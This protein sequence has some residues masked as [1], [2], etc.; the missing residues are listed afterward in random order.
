MSKRIGIFLLAIITMIGALPIEVIA[1]GMDDRAANLVGNTPGSLVESND[2]QYSEEKNK[3]SETEIILESAKETAEQNNKSKKAKQTQEKES[4]GEVNT[5]A[6]TQPM[7]FDVQKI[8]NQPQGDILREIIKNNNYGL[9]WNNPEN[10]VGKEATLEENLIEGSIDYL[11]A[12]EVIGNT[13]FSNKI[14]AIINKDDTGKAES[15][16][17]V[18]KTKTEGEASEQTNHFITIRDA[19]LNYP[20]IETRKFDTI[21]GENTYNPYTN[22]TYRDI[23]NQIQRIT[24]G[25]ISS[26]IQEATEVNSPVPNKVTQTIVKTPILAEQ[27]SYTLIIR[28]ETKIGREIKNSYKTFTINTDNTITYNAVLTNGI[29]RENTINWLK[30][31]VNTTDETQNFTVDLTPDNSQKVLNTIQVK[32]YKLTEKGYEEI[33]AEREVKEINSLPEESAKINQIQKVEKQIESKNEMTTFGMFKIAQKTVEAE[34]ITQENKTTEP[35]ERQETEPIETTEE[36]PQIVKTAPTATASTT[37]AASIAA[38]GLEA[39]N[40]VPKRQETETTIEENS[41]PKVEDTTETNT[42]PKEKVEPKP[43][44]ISTIPTDI[45]VERLNRAEDLKEN[46]KSN[47]V[48]T[49]ELAPGEIAIAELKTEIVDP[50]AEHTVPDGKV[51]KRTN[52]LFP[53]EDYE[54]LRRRTVPD[55]ELKLARSRTDSGYEYTV[56]TDRTQVG[57]SERFQVS[58]EFNSSSGHLPKGGDEFTIPI[59][60]NSVKISKDGIVEPLFDKSGKQLG[61]ATIYNDKI[62]FKMYDTVNGLEKV[63]GGLKFW[64][65]GSYTGGRDRP[66]EGTIEIGGKKV[67]VNY[68]PGGSTTNNV[69]RKTGV[70][71]DRPGYEGIVHWGFVIN[72]AQRETEAVNYTIRDTLNDKMDW[73]IDKI[74]EDKIVKINTKDD[75]TKYYLMLLFN[76]KGNIQKQELDG[77]VYYDL[78]KA[79]AEEFLGVKI[80]INGN[81]LTITSSKNGYY[82][83]NNGSWQPLLNKTTLQITLPAKIKEQYLNDKE[84]H[85]V[86][87]TSEVDISNKADWKVEEKDKSY[88]VQLFKSESW[89]KGIQP[90]E[91]K[92]LKVAK[93][94]GDINPETIEGV[95]FELKSNSGNDLS[96]VKVDK[97][98]KVDHTETGAIRIK[99]DENGLIYLKKLPTGEYTL[100]EVEA[101]E[102]VVI[103]SQERIF[104]AEENSKGQ[105]Y[106]IENE[107]KRIDIKVEKEWKDS[108]GTHPEVKFKLLRKIEGSD[109]SE[110]K[111][112]TTEEEPSYSQLTLLSE[113]KEVTWK[114]LRAHDKQSNKPYTYKVEE[115][116]DEINKEE[117]GSEEKPEGKEKE[118]SKEGIVTIGGVKYK[119][120]VEP[121]ETLLDKLIGK[122][123]GTITFKV[124]NEKQDSKKGKFTLK[125]VNER[126]EFLNGA[127]FTLTKKDGEQLPKEFAQKEIKVEKEEGVLVDNLDPGIYLLK[128]TKAPGGYTKTNETATITVDEKG[129]TKV[130]S[131]TR[132]S[133]DI[134]VK[135]DNKKVLSYDNKEL[136]IVIAVENKYPRGMKQRYDDYKNTAES[137]YNAFKNTPGLKGKVNIILAGTGANNTNVVDFNIGSEFQFPEN[138]N[139][140]GWMDQ[141]FT[142]A[143]PIFKNSSNAENILITLFEGAYNGSNADKALRELSSTNINKVFNYTYSETWL[144][145]INNSLIDRYN[146]LNIKTNLGFNSMISKSMFDSDRDLYVSEYITGLDKDRNI[147]TSPKGSHIRENTVAV[148]TVTIQNGIFA[149]LIINK[150]DK[151]DGSK[152]LQGA[153]FTLTK[154]DGTESLTAVSTTNGI[155]IFDKIAPGEYI[156]KETQAPNKYKKIETEW[157]VYVSPT[158]SI[159]VNEK[160]DNVTPQETKG[161]DLS[162][163]LSGNIFISTPKTQNNTLEIGKDS[164]KITI[165]GNFNLNGV[166]AGDYFDLKISNTIHYNMLQPDKPNQPTIMNSAGERIAVPTLIKSSLG[167]EKII[168]YTFVNSLQNVEFQF[169]LDYSVDVFGAK[170][171]GNYKF[172]ANVGHT[173]G[174]IDRQV[175]Y[176]GG[177]SNSYGLNIDA[178][179]DYTNDQNG[180]YSQVIYVNQKGENITVPTHLEITPY[181]AKDYKNG[182]IVANISPIATAIKVYK[183]KSGQSLSNAV[184]Y[185]KDKLE[186]VTDQFKDKIKID[187]GK[188]TIQFDNIG[189]EKYVVVVDSNMIYPQGQIQGTYLVQVAKL[190]NNNTSASIQMNSGIATTDSSSLGSGSTYS[191]NSIEL[192][193][194][195]EKEET[196]K[197]TLKKTDENQKFLKG[198]VFTLSKKENEKLPESFVDREIKID[199]PEGVLVDNLDSGIYMLE[200]KVSPTGYKSNDDYIVIVHQSG[201]TQ[202]IEKKIFDQLDRSILKEETDPEELFNINNNSVDMSRPAKLLQNLEVYDYEL[203]SSNSKDPGIVRPNYG[204]YLITRFKIKIPAEAKEGDYFYTTFDER[205]NRLGNKLFE[206]NIQP[207]KSYTGEELIR[208]SNKNGDNTYK[209]ILTEKVNNKQDFEIELELPLYV[210]RNV[211]KENSILDIVNI[212]PSTGKDTEE[213]KQAD[214][215]AQISRKIRVDYSGFSQKANNGDDYV[216]SAIYY[217][218]TTSTA[219]S[220][221]YLYGSK[222][223]GDKISS[224]IYSRFQGLKSSMNLFSED[225]SIEVYKVNKPFTKVDGTEYKLDP[226]TMPESFGLDSNWIASK[227]KSNTIIKL[228]ENGD[229]LS[230]TKEY[231]NSQYGYRWH[232]DINDD[233]NNERVEAYG[234]I[235]KVNSKYDPYSENPLRIVAG[236]RKSNYYNYTNSNVAFDNEIIN[237]SPSASIKSTNSIKLLKVDE[238]GSMISDTIFKLTSVKGEEVYSQY[239]KTDEKGQIIFGKIKAGDYNLEEIVTAHGYEKPSSGWKISVV[240]DEK[241]GVITSVQSTPQLRIDNNTEGGIYEITVTNKKSDDNNTSR[242]VINYPNKITFYKVGEE[243]I[244][245]IGAEFKLLRNNDSSYVQERIIGEDNKIGEIS[246]EKL[247]PGDYT[248]YETKVPEGYPSVANSGKVASFKV[249]SNGKITEVKTLGESGKIED[250][251]GTHII[252]NKI[253][254]IKLKIEKRDGLDNNLLGGAKF[255]LYV[256][257]SGERKQITIKRV[258]KND[259]LGEKANYETEQSEWETQL[260]EGA[261]KGTV[262]IEGLLDGIYWLKETKAPEG[263]VAYGDFIGPIKIQ[264]GKV[265][266]PTEQKEPLTL[267][268]ENGE[269]PV[270]VAT[271]TNR[272]P[273]YPSTGGMGTVPF[274]GAGVS[275]MAL[276]WYELRKRKYDNKGGGIN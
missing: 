69:Y 73:A 188:A 175:S 203:V 155:A 182:Y 123:E 169:N 30:T 166:K 251:K 49:V 237:A 243:G 90:K 171:N 100:K 248:L 126:Q 242:N 117:P 263:Y 145:N 103:D 127:V 205:L 187:Y 258:V 244:P 170:N 46:F 181:V 104:K 142:K 160:K 29:Q 146:K 164:N 116:G 223:A 241:T 262:I 271:V 8:Q 202:V 143:T 138:N 101:P 259:K 7:Q 9:D 154:K 265:N 177:K 119:S 191:S 204:E 105:T 196:G 77:Q 276:A 247:S 274:V 178:S 199:K 31:V 80:E 72:E 272:K 217:D 88:R 254:E 209:Y 114:G 18:Y 10:Y 267:K 23:Q 50:K 75:L 206:G 130:T 165:K 17:W 153:E 158:G 151:A 168:R 156:L 200:E 144:Q 64:I 122:N 25:N 136:N 184:I 270:N 27:N 20:I 76:G 132:P 62:V 121:K 110:F 167:G 95:T 93:G 12:P 43:E 207:I 141:A 120:T 240:K 147:T 36:V 176:S 33:S 83:I 125:K 61:Q 96:N 51:Y 235:V 256:E 16:T 266:V 52:P 56:D 34:K 14:E 210:N 161:E 255:E 189:T 231:Q 81:S 74:N 84:T 79:E 211:V 112:V 24:T 239:G 87:N 269:N 185:E 186:D 174:E 260:I 212:I 233:T 15:I 41:S 257:D 234:Y 70:L 264:G 194:Q 140:A 57:D 2:Q 179:F 118:S 107:I 78:N 135:E 152:K 32:K 246:F 102:G 19:G 66:G 39:E 109:D 250:S 22:I 21:E 82:F 38:E 222:E 28:T 63:E 59:D 229:D 232:L 215:K 228:N 227:I 172:S 131:D 195:N 11:E 1:A 134:S 91:L 97:G 92:I 193:V 180:K 86:E 198:S 219:E 173:R 253:S 89:I 249:T 13:T 261:G 225:P 128:E 220:Y 68:Y 26:P 106:K 98:T 6:E 252:V 85:Y 268:I 129:N 162:D 213:A 148:P 133:Q 44:T 149:K 65:S 47:T 5:Q 197:F 94:T 37:L 108:E 48:E 183:V 137:I 216:G 67:T 111:E 53:G 124:T 60:S 214:A 163:K 190:I 40:G 238:N 35:P 150:T 54:D 71:D 3:N 201:N 230:F 159:F 139:I 42:E 55:G 224:N 45:I 208:I 157:N 113:Q 236:L 245:I 58:I 275:L 192:N 273:V 218:P 221:I 4:I 226:E 99:T 115:V